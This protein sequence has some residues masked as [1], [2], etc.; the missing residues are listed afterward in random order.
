MEE[1]FQSASLPGY[2]VHSAQRGSKPIPS[3]H[4]MVAL[5]KVAAEWTNHPVIVQ[6][7]HDM[8]Q[9]AGWGADLHI[10]K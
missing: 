8:T 6:S 4:C 3:I 7:P 1:I 10:T 5:Y 2:T 9:D